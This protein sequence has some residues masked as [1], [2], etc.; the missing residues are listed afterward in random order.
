MEFKLNKKELLEVLLTGS[1]FAGTNR[2]ISM[3]DNVRIKMSSGSLTVE[4]TNGE[5]AIKS[6]IAISNSTGDFDFCIQP[7]DLVKELSVCEL[8]KA[9]EM[10]LGHI[11]A[12]EA[13]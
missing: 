13:N 8:A 5:N 2:T 6:R 1:K 9:V 12:V 7:Q 11:L 4:S 3:F 10:E